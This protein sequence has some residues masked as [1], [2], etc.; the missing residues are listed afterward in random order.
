M[1]AAEQERWEIALVEMRIEK[2]ERFM[3]PEQ[4]PL[5]AQTLAGFEGLDYYFP[6]PGLRY[7]LA[8]TPAAS[9]D[10]VRLERRTGGT[11][12]VVGAMQT[13]GTDIESDSNWG[14]ALSA[15]DVNKSLKVQV[16]GALSTNVRWVALIEVVEVTYS[17]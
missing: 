3:D 16:Q 17:D 12:A 15:D 10:T 9:V 14:M 7:R 11:V 1:D 4:T 13:I 6:H 2:N 5:P 8:L